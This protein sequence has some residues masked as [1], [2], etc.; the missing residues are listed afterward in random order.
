MITPVVLYGLAAMTFSSNQAARF[1][2]VQ[3]KM[4]RAF[5]GWTRLQ[6]EEWRDTMSRMKQ[7][8]KAAKELSSM[9]DWSAELSKRKWRWAGEIAKLD[10]SRWPRK[11]VE[12]SP[13]QVQQQT[14]SPVKRK[15]GR[16]R[17]RWEDPLNAYSKTKGYRDWLHFAQSAP[18]HWNSCED[19]YLEAYG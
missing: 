6:D 2:R 18:E 7:R 9:R 12:W 1:N 4:L 10:E 3:N 5:V 13:N 19:E 11:L 15:V 14:W 8:V 17:T 16:P